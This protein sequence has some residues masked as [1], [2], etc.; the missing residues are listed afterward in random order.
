MKTKLALAA[1]LALFM[2]HTGV[3]IANSNANQCSSGSPVVS[4]EG[5]PLTNGFGGPVCAE[6]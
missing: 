1:I 4:S 5:T 6:K 3:T 2:S